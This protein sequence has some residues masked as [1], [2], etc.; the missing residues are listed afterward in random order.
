MK[1]L[2]GNYLEMIRSSVTKFCRH[3][4]FDQGKSIVNKNKIVKNLPQQSQVA[5]ERTNEM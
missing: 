5:V 4:H 3:I 2:R 1:C